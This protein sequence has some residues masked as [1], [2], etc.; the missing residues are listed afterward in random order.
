MSLARPLARAAARTIARSV[1]AGTGGLVYASM[2]EAEVNSD[3]WSDGDIVTVNTVQ[4]RYLSTLDTDG[5][6][7]LIHRYPTGTPGDLDVGSVVLHASEPTNT[8]PDAYSPAWTDV[9]TGVK[10]TDYDFATENSLGLYSSITATGSAFMNGPVAVTS[11][12]TSVFMIVDSAQAV[13]GG[14][15]GG[16][17]LLHAYSDGVNDWQTMLRVKT[18]SSATNWVIQTAST[19]YEDTGIA[20][21]TTT[22]LW[23]YLVGGATSAVWI[24]DGTAPELT[25]TD[26]RNP[27]TNSVGRMLS[28]SGSAGNKL[29]VGYHL[30]GRAVAA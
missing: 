4:F 28:H 24:D 9:S 13:S 29:R 16:A 22:R 7:G 17:I 27:T 23:I 15:D 19:T 2:A 20:F 11:S 1:T 21:G 12:D 26:P 30:H 14:S 8:D 10:A 25:D 3:V 18:T 5:H 6:S